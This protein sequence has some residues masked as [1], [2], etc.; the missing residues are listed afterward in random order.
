[1]TTIKVEGFEFTPEQARKVYEELRGVFEPPVQI[2]DITDSGGCVTWV[3]KD[4]PGMP[5]AAWPL[6]PPYITSSGQ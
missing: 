2:Y 4:S 5:F 1:M 6:T 3:K